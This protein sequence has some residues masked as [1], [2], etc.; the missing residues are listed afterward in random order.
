MKL[1]ITSELPD[2]H[3]VFAARSRAKFLAESARIQIGLEGE[4]RE[5]ELS[6]ASRRV[7]TSSQRA[8]PDAI[9]T[10]L[11]DGDGEI[12][13][14]RINAFRRDFLSRSRQLRFLHDIL[15]LFYFES[16]KILEVNSV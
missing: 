8:E 4:V 6:G 10:G 3:Q 16:F 14:E 1:F 7:L 9:K 11:I 2:K 5:L 13:V 15:I 12:T